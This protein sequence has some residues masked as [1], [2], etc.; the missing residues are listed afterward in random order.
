MTKEDYVSQKIFYLGTTKYQQL[1]PYSLTVLSD[2]QTF[3]NYSLKY[4]PYKV[5][6]V[7]HD[8]KYYIKLLLFEKLVNS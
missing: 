7:T 2:L 3:T 4:L 1:F 5:V 8:F 6:E